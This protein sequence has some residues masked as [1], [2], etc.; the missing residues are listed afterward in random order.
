MCSFIVVGDDGALAI[1]KLHVLD[2]IMNEQ[3]RVFGAAGLLA[4]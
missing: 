2:L 3:V 4:S 1:H